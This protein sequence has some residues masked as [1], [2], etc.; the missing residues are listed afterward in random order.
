MKNDHVEN[1]IQTAV[2]N[3]KGELLL[4]KRSRHEKVHKSK[5]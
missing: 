5:D 3:E 4:E 2:L 1:I